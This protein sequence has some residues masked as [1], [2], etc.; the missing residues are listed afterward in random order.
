MVGCKKRP[1][2]ETLAGLV[3][4]IACQD[5][6]GYPIPGGLVRGIAYQ[7]PLGYPILGALLPAVP[8]RRV[9]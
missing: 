1:K 9:L 5:P 3:Q 7:D 6:F 4:G 2:R 8:L